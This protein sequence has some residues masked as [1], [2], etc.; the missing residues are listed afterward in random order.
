M[1]S[2]MT[3]CPAYIVCPIIEYHF[4]QDARVHNA[5]DDVACTIYQALPI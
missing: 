5:L 3:W 1:R 2:P 4:T